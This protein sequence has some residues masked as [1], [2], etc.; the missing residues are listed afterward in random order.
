MSERRSILKIRLLLSLLVL[1]LCLSACY[2]SDV[3]QPSDDTSPEQSSEST[4]QEPSDEPDEQYSRA[5]IAR[6]LL[7]DKLVH[8]IFAG[9]YLTGGE[10]TSDYVEVTGEYADF[11]AIS[12][13]LEST[14]DSTCGVIEHYLELPEYGRNAVIEGDD[15]RTYC[16]YHYIDDR[17]IAYS[18]FV[19]GDDSVT[20]GDITLPLVRTDDGIRLGGTLYSERQ[21]ISPKS[22]KMDVGSAKKLGGRYLAVLILMSQNDYVLSD[23]EERKFKSSVDGAIELVSDIS[24]QYGA[25]TIFDVSV[26][27]FVHSESVGGDFELDMMLAGTSFRTL[28]GLITSQ[29]DTKEYDG[30]FAI[31]CSID[32]E[33]VAYTAY[34]DGLPDTNCCERLIVGIDADEKAIAAAVFGICG[35]EKRGDD[36]KATEYFGID[37]MDGGDGLS[38]I[39]AYRVGLTEQID[40]Q[41]GSF[42]KQQ[43]E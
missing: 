4:G 2:N 16:Y 19:I 11:A 35:A 5:E 10:T 37:I 38:D 22:E 26:M 33:G 17:D 34:Y 41:L 24:K 28:D 36:K 14:Y 1:V 39:N 42:I 31:C 7:N 32:V 25:E 29:C 18:N 12:A 3:Q 8:M 9:G 40:S 23:G 21:Y 20:V 6:L 30:Y 43:T 13:L 27:R 15:G